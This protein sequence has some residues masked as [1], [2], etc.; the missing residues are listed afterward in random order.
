MTMRK[1]MKTK[2]SSLKGFSHLERTY[3]DLKSRGRDVQL[4]LRI[5]RPRLL[6]SIEI[7][8]EEI[9]T[10]LKEWPEIRSVDGT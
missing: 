2:K 7:S 10:L 3:R 9:D 6:M 5:G 8:K 4:I 1:T